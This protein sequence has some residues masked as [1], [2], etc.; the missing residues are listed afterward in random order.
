MVLT[1]AGVPAERGPPQPVG[2]TLQQSPGERTYPTPHTVGSR[3]GSGQAISLSHKKYVKGCV[4]GSCTPR[5]QGE[6]QRSRHVGALILPKLMLA[7]PDGLAWSSHASSLL[8]YQK[9][10]GRW[11]LPEPPRLVS[12]QRSMPCGG[13]SGVCLVPC[14]L[15]C[16][17]YG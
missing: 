14:S 12:H 5:T 16:V 17:P 11:T 8:S 10:E 3:G 4:D 2:W 9:G 1:V 15:N 6:P 13:R 7:A